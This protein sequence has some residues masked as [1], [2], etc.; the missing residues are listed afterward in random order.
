MAGPQHRALSGRW[1]RAEGDVAE[2]QCGSCNEWLEVSRDFWYFQRAFGVLVPHSWCKGC[3]RL[4]SGRGPGMRRKGF[5][6]VRPAPGK[7]LPAQ[8]VSLDPMAAIQAAFLSLPRPG[9]RLLAPA[10]MPCL[11]AA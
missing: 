8:Y 5:T 4:R 2:A 7:P 11:E 3:Y 10:L 9:A 6:F 1:R